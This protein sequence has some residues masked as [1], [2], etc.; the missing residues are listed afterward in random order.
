MFV[1]ELKLCRQYALQ[2]ICVSMY[3]VVIIH[4]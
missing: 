1:T 2:L 4:C 3:N